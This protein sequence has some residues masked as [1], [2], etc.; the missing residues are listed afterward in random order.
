MT[1]IDDDHDWCFDV[2]AVLRAAW[3]LLECAC[4]PVPGSARCQLQ[5]VAAQ[6]KLHAVGLGGLR[7]R[8]GSCSGGQLP[9][10]A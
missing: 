8:Y 6:R 7:H 5:Q 10:S 4:A 9:P 2:E 1:K 3:S